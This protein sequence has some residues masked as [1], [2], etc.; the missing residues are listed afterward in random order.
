[1]A[2]KNLLITDFSYSNDCITLKI[3]KTALDGLINILNGIF[4][5]ETL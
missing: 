1:M 4:K 5:A 2:N 3:E